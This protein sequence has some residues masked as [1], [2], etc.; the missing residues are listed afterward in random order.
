[1]EAAFDL[2][3]LPNADLGGRISAGA[4]LGRLRLEVSFGDWLSQQATASPPR[5]TQG[6]TLH[7]L[8]GA[9]RGCFR[10][11]PVRR[12]EIDPCAGAGLTYVTS[13]GFGESVFFA[14][15]TAK[16]AT[17]GSAYADALIVVAVAGPLALRG[18]VGLAIPLVRPEFDIQ[19]EGNPSS[20]IFLHQAS[21][22]AGRAG[23]GVE[24]RFP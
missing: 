8:E 9:L 18:S 21:S 17:W 15:E 16:G 2:G 4:L 6:T 20:V 19:E 14:G 1:M 24:V 23:L 13:N 22:V 12:L 10:W 7:P 3:T 5:T 11:T